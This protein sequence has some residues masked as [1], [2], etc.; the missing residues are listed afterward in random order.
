MTVVIGYIPG[1]YGEAALAAGIEEARRRHTG[2]VVVNASKGDALVDRKYLGEAARGEL[3]DRL[4]ESG[5]PHE[6]RQIVGADVADELLGVARDTTA[7]AIVIGLRHRTPVG[8]MIMG[9]VA[10]RVLLD[11]SC[12]VIAVKPG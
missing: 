1:D 11:A 3:E 5:V 8:K 10:Q 9:S 2:I 4:R 6:I 7:E 12:P